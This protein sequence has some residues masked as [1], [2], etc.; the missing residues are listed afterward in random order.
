M[1]IQA[2]VHRLEHLLK[3]VKERKREKV[4]HQERAA[5]P[6]ETVLVMGFFLLFL[7]VISISKI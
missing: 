6:V 5:D 2:G 7:A 3:K 4:I 1:R